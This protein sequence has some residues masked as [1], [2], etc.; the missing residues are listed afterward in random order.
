MIQNII[1]A[2]VLV[3]FFIFFYYALH[4]VP[5]LDQMVIDLRN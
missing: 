1:D 5:L 4:L 2:I 3:V